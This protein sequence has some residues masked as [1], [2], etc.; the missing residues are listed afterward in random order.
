[1]FAV[2]Y[3]YMFFVV[4][5]CTGGG[6]HSALVFDVLGKLL[7]SIGKECLASSQVEGNSEVALILSVLM[8]TLL[9]SASSTGLG[10]PSTGAVLSTENAS[11]GAPMN[12]T[13][14]RL[15]HNDV[16]AFLRSPMSVDCGWNVDTNLVTYLEFAINT[17]KDMDRDRHTQLALLYLGHVKQMLSKTTGPLINRVCMSIASH[18]HPLPLSVTL[19]RPRSVSANPSP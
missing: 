14:T 10:R 2:S 18:P 12:A 1:M 8:P 19:A 15:A 9:A 13:T 4:I 7:R 16:L 3:L 17:M 5:A 6:E 11:V